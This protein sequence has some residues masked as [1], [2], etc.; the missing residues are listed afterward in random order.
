MENKMIEI[1]KK[2]VSLLDNV[3]SLDEFNDWKEQTQIFIC[4]IYKENSTQFN[5]F[6]RI[7]AFPSI[8]TPGTQPNIPEA[9]RES[10]N[11]LNGFII[12]LET[13]GLPD[14]TEKKDKNKKTQL[15]NIHIEN[16]LSQ[17]QNQH[18]TQNFNIKEIIKDE[19]PPS[20]M[21]EIEDILKTNESEKTKFEKI[22]EILQKVGIGV[23]SSVLARI[24]TTSIG[25]W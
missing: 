13:F 18:Q 22:G 20:K 10:K 21:R 9:I 11:I 2:Q 8:Y 14:I 23:T 25:L 19:L 6:I 15:P 1:L 5:Q 24:I 17:S 3:N 7:S 4:R 16:N 12:D